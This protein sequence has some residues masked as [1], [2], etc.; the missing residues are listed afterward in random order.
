[1]SAVYSVGLMT[2]LSRTL[3][4]N[5]FSD[6]NIV[7][8]ANSDLRSIKLLINGLA[9][10]KSYYDARF[11]VHKVWSLRKKV[12]HRVFS[13]KSHDIDLM[14]HLADALE[15]EEFSPSE[16]NK[17]KQYSNLKGLRNFAKGLSTINYLIPD[18]DLAVGPYL[19]KGWSVYNHNN[20]DFHNFDPSKVILLSTE[21]DPKLLKLRGKEMADYLLNLNGLTAN[22][23]D[24]LNVNSIWIPKEWNHEAIVFPGSIFMN[25]GEYYARYIYKFGEIW[26][27][28]WC[29]LEN[30]FP[31]EYKVVII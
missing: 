19:Q 25:N 16:V 20:Q 11:V 5:G 13:K 18:F 15:R 14:N 12:T 31:E 3:R 8:L 27:T 24:W 2:Q 22:V 23:A 28:H 30:K 9:E 4:N 6:E 26:R 7:S 10:I 17:L 29:Y 21:D 1:M